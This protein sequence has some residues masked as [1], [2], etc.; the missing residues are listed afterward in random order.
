MNKFKLISFLSTLGMKAG[1]T[2]SDVG[3]ALVGK[4]VALAALTCHDMRQLAIHCEKENVENVFVPHITKPKSLLLMSGFEL[5]CIICHVQQEFGTTNTAM[6]DRCNANISKFPKPEMIDV[7]LR[8]LQRGY[9]EC[10]QP[11]L[12]TYT[13][14]DERVRELSLDVSDTTPP[15]EP[16]AR[17]LLDRVANL[18]L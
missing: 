14:I 5:T 13:G 17:T 9:D 3:I 7:I 11:E 12:W 6:F 18:R 2:L 15:P 16:K 8:A 10:G 4:K 1:M